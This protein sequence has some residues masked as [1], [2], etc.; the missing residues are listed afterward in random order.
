M[1]RSWSPAQVN[2]RGEHDSKWPKDHNVKEQNFEDLNRRCWILHDKELYPKTWRRRRQGPICK[3]EQVNNWPRSVGDCT[4]AE[5]GL[6]RSAQGSRHG[7]FQAYFMTPF[8]LGVSLWI[9]S[10]S[11]GRHIHPFIR[12]SPKQRRRTGR[13]T[14][15][16]AS[17]QGCPGDGL[18]LP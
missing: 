15:A 8:D 1:R 18:G 10:A 12:E 13:H 11:I 6:G 3:R 16:T 14:T 17:P 7:L 4:E 2:T 9:T 5:T